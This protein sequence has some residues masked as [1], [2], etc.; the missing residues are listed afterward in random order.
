MLLITSILGLSSIWRALRRARPAILSIAILYALS[1]LVG[2]IMVQTGY[3]PALAY[4]DYIVSRAQS[5][6]TLIALN[7]GDRL[8]AALRDFYGNLVL[9]AVPNTLGGLGVVF[10][11][12]LVVYQGW[13]GGIVSVNSAHVSRLATFSGGFY[14]LATLVLQLVPYSL[15]AGAGV[16]LGLSLW[17]KQTYYEGGRWLGFPKE[18]VLD[19]LRIYALV[20]PLFL[21]AS[22]WEFLAL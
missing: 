5:D 19:V 8:G 21:V 13:I 1:L 16:N 22:L 6:P 14:Y 7:S 20:V 2:A 10:P 3:Q 12:P 9:G 11:Y 18:A 4:R 15:A 17:R